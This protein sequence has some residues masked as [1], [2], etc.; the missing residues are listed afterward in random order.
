[1]DRFLNALK[2]QAS[3]LD[4]SM[5]QPRFGVV[6]SVDSARHAVRVRVQPEDV[7]TGWLPVLV[8]WVGAGWGM[9]CPPSPGDQVLLLPQEGDAENGLVVGACYSDK[10]RPPPAPPGELWLVHRSGAALRLSNDGTVRVQ[11]DLHVD[12]DIYDRFGRLNALRD[13]YN[14]HTHPS[15]SSTQPVPQD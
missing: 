9:A 12:G 11:G 8:P 15:G 14:A 4:Q 5:G 1:M 6:A 7:L 13:H 10:A 2:A 3:A